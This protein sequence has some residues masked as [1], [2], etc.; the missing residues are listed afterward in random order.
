MLSERVGPAAHMYRYF[1][2]LYRKADASLYV[3]NGVGSWFPLRLNA[4][5][6]SPT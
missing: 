6:R 2:G 3:S 4:R 1:R 5:P